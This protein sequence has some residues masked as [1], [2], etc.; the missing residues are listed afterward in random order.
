MISGY[1]CHTSGGSGNYMLFC[2]MHK[3]VDVEMVTDAIA[4][5]L[6]GVSMS[7]IKDVLPIAFI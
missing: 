6:Q 2:I 5:V 4:Y 7:Y 3:Q 1:M